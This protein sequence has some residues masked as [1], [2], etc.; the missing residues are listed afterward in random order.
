MIQNVFISIIF[1]RMWK[2]EFRELVNR[3]VEFL[4]QHNPEVLNLKY[5]Y[6]KLVDAQTSLH[7]LRV[8]LGAHP[9]SEE[10]SEYRMK[11]NKLI[12]AIVGHIRVLKK[13]K[14]VIN[15]PN[16]EIVSKFV[17]RYLN[18]IVNSNSSKKTDTITEMFEVLDSD[19]SLTD[20]I[21]GLNLKSYFDELRVLQLSYIQTV[22]ERSQS[23]TEN[24]KIETQVVRANAEIALR[25]VMSE[26]ELMQL[27]HPE[28]DYKPLIMNLN[29]TFSSAMVKV[30]ARSTRK[31]TFAETSKVANHNTAT[32]A[33]NGNSDAVA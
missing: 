31:K 9:K 12:G 28:L 23:Y 27:K 11:R 20:A 8:P 5:V 21:A 25:N 29:E 16:V 7:L 26:I 10:L 6:D 3:V 15:L 22:S 33:Q 4:N 19:S 1:S 30:K 24:Q 18:P 17:A 14:T 13:A 2:S 32:T